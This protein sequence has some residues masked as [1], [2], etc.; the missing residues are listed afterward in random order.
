ME[1]DY[2]FI[3]QDDD[4]EAAEQVR[5]KLREAGWISDSDE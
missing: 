1:R 4:G 2:T 3:I 5:E